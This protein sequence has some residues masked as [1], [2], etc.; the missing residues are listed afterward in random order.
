M[1]LTPDDIAQKAFTPRFR[2]IDPVEV[3]E[4]LLLAAAQISDLHEQIRQQNEQIGEQE[5]ELALAAD[6]KKSFDDVLDVFKQKIDTLSAQLDEASQKQAGREKELERVKQL[7]EGVQRDRAGLDCVAK[8]EGPK[9]TGVVVWVG[10]K[11]GH[12][13]PAHRPPRRRSARRPPAESPRRRRLWRCSR[14]CSG[15]WCRHRAAAA[16]GRPVSSRETAP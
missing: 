2:G 14:A 13:R 12:A 6:D 3:R 9:E 16:H 7:L 15:A 5:K 4:F 1:A 8:M 11:P 10:V